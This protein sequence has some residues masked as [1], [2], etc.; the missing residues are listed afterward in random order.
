MFSAFSLPHFNRKPLLRCATISAAILALLFLLHGPVT[1]V[2]IYLPNILAGLVL[3]LT[4]RMQVKYYIPATT[5]ALAVISGGEFYLYATLMLGR[6]VFQA[7]AD[8]LSKYEF[9]KIPPE[10]AV[11]CTVFYLCMFC[12]VMA[13]MKTLIA[14]SLRRIILRKFPGVEK[15]L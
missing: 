5:A 14:L 13:G 3:G 4:Y 2:V 12:I 15:L 11:L 7:V 9:L 1:G 10:W 8:T 6:S